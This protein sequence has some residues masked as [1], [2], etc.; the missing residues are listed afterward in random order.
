MRARLFA[1]LF[2]LAAAGCSGDFPRDPERTLE[3]IRATRQFDVGVIAPVMQDRGGHLV[4]AFVERMERASG[5]D[6]RI[7]IGDAEPL[8]K[9]LEEG[10]IDIVIGR[11]DKKSPWGKLVTIGPPL[12][13]EMRGKAE[14]HLVPAMQNGEN[15]WIALVEGEARDL[16]PEAQ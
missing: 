6:A 8:L 10:E 16:A 9:R 14:L 1:C 4:R 11:F 13:T 7:E 12:D 5:A 2:V 3:T 15:A